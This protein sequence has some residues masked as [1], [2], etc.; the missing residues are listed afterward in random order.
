MAY[1]YDLTELVIN[2]IDETLNYIINKLYN[3]KAIDL[4]NWKSRFQFLFYILLIIN[5][6]KLEL[7]GS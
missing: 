3:K 1:S 6:L 4:K 2:D 7:K 5:L